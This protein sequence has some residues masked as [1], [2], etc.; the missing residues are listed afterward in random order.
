MADLSQYVDFSVQLDKSGITPVIVLTDTSVYPTGVK[1]TITGVFSVVQPDKINISGNFITPDVVYSVS[2]LTVANKELRAATDGN[3]QKGLYVFTYV[4]KA[5]GYDDTV[6]TK[7]FELSYDKP[8]IE[9][10]NLTDVFEPSIQVIDSTDYSKTGFT[11]TTVWSWSADIQK[12]IDTIRTITGAAALFDI[13][14][15]NNYYDAHY[16]ISFQSIVTYTSITYTWFSIKDKLTKELQLDVYA[17]PTIAD[18]AGGLYTMEQEIIF[19]TYCGGCGCN[20]RKTFDK[21]NALYNTFVENGKNGINTTGLYAYVLQLQKL[22]NCSGLLNLKHTNVALTPYDWGSSTGGAEHEAIQFTVGSGR[23]F[24]PVDTDTSYYNPA[25]IRY[26]V[27]QVF[28]GSVARFLD[29]SEWAVAQGGFT[30]TGLTFNEGDKYTVLF[31]D[32]GGSKSSFQFT[33]QEAY[34]LKGLIS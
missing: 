32:A 23:P 10:D 2:D 19:G 9:I 4:V 3:F 17:P 5:T 30:L 24:V 15:L 11:H 29:E 27:K 22:F 31:S 6:K 13:V 18:L 16:H 8:V 34:L 20:G 7:A 25:L 14:Y 26:T 12:V 21:A 28:S 33:Q 1:A